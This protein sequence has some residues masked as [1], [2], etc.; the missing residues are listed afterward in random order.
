MRVA[1]T[2]WLPLG[3]TLIAGTI[4]FCALG[5]AIGNF[6]GPNSAS[7]TVNMIY[8]PLSFCSGLWVPLMFLPKLMQQ[9]AHWLPS[10]HLAQLALAVLR[11]SVEGSVGRHVEALAAFTL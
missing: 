6:S 7:P 5:L 3:G 2:Q 1:L 9:V 8:M 10:Y 11:P 4:P